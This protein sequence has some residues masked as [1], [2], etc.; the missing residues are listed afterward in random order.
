MSP[1]TSQTKVCPTCGTRLNEN[2][3]RCLVC[4]RNFAPSAAPAKSG[5]TSKNVQG[6]RIPE[7][8]LSLPVAIGLVVL[9]LGLGAVIVYAILAGSNAAASVGLTPTPTA[10]NTP[11]VTFTPTA[12]ATPT[13]TPTFTPEPP[14]DYQVLSGEVCSSIALKFGVTVDSIAKLNNFPPD[15]GTLFVGQ[16]I[17]IPRPTPTPPPAATPTLSAQEATEQAC[18]V[19]DYVVK[20]GDTL[21]GIARA[22]NIDIEVL[23]NANGLPTDNIYSGMQLK[24]PLCQRLPT[25]GP[26]PTATPPPPYTAPN[27]LL[28]VDGTIFNFTDDA[29]TL[30]WSA[31]G[32]LRTNEAYAVMIEDVTSGEGARSISYVTDTKFIVPTSLRPKDGRT[33]IFRWT[34]MA[35]R[36]KGVTADGQPIW[37]P[38]GAVSLARVFGWQGG[39]VG[40]PVP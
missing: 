31:V 5:A 28:P 32:P 21:G 35:V 1:D 37:D 6:P 10:S 17:K 39:P 33:H 24:I 3:T 4:G 34:V 27:L 18:G 26:T 2:A 9:M 25:A 11:T 7:V 38:G 23:R 40:T 13:I 8:R 15:C 30:Q 29:I 20:D 12:S 14:V 19:A 36:Q 16:T 22:Y